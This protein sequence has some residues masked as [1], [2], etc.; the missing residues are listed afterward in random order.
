MDPNSFHIAQKQ[1]EKILKL[2][3]VLSSVEVNT[4]VFNRGKISKR[5]REMGNNENL[6]PRIIL[7]WEVGILNGKNWNRNH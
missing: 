3:L 4:S 1:I 5:M 2:V 6:H 7:K